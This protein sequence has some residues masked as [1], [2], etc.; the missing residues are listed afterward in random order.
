[1]PPTVQTALRPL[2]AILRPFVEFIYPPVC[3]ACER[4]LDSPGR[5]ICL[6]CTGS[7]R[8]VSTVD[9][10]YRQTLGNLS[11][12]GCVDG[13][14]SVFYFDKDGPLQSL[15]HQL[16]YSGTTSLGVEL[17]RHLAEGIASSD[18]FRDAV[19]VPVPLH[20]T[21]LRERGYNQSDYVCRGISEVTGLQAER[22]LR[23]QRYTQSQTQL[24]A[25]ERRDNVAGAFSLARV[26]EAET[27]LLVD[28][29]ITTGATIHACAQ[30]LKQHGTA[31]V[32]A[33]SLALA[34]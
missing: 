20:R 4:P 10:I 6:E 3:F 27:V 22:C 17:G 29:V 12:D 2:G 5:R 7:I 21:K 30:V 23:R 18:C 32:I 25:D 28:D 13:L 8:R 14:I 1:M 33:C 15:I 9:E 34:P 11:A 16:K 24:S 26:P 31:S 19:L